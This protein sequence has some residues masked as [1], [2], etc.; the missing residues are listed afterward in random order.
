MVKPLSCKMA[1][2][3]R[4]NT[5]IKGTECYRISAGVFNNLGI[6]DDNTWLFKIWFATSLW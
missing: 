5:D 1:Q 4:E 6:T 2:Y 3:N